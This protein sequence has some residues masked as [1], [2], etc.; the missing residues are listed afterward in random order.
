MMI[1]TID[2]MINCPRDLLPTK[3]S[4]GQFAVYEKGAFGRFVTAAQAVQVK[5]AIT[6]RICVS[7]LNQWQNF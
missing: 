3:S 5:K 1:E 4:A 6:S 7:F 2:Q